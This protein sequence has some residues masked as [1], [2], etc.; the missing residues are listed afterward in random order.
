[1]L[2]EEEAGEKKKADIW[3]VVAGFY[4]IPPLKD[5]NPPPLREARPLPG[6]RDGSRALVCTRVRGCL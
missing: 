6:A 4:L 1:M 3:G 2:K 5:L